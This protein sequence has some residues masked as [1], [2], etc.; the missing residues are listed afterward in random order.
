M[1]EFSFLSRA[2]RP[3]H[4]EFGHFECYGDITPIIRLFVGGVSRFG[5]SGT[6]VFDKLRLISYASESPPLGV[7]SGYRDNSSSYLAT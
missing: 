4:P 3:T 6:D 5:I 7:T 1:C 2:C